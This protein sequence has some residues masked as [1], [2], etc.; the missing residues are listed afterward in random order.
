VGSMITQKHAPRTKLAAARTKE[1]S[2]R[3]AAALP[4]SLAWHLLAGVDRYRLGHIN[5]EKSC[6]AESKFLLLV[7][8]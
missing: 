1:L 2:R 7:R 8:C 5:K 6:A 4:W 3:R